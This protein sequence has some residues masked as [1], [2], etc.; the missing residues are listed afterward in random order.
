MCIRDRIHTANIT[1]VGV[2]NILEAMRAEKPD[3]RF[4]QASSSEMYGLIQQL[5]L[6][7]I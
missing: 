1:A 2:T 6:I 7:H 5:S 3:A 4:Y